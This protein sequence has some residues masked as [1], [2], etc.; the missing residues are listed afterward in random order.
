LLR[1]QYLFKEI[2]AVLVKKVVDGKRNNWKR[3]LKR[4]R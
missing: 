3:G 2:P 1:G 4:R